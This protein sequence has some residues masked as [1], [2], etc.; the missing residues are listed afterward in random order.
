VNY[1]TAD[2]TATAPSDYTAGSGTVSF[3][4]G[5]SVQTATVSVAGDTLAEPNESFT[6]SLSAP[7]G[8]TLARTVATAT[9]LDDESSDLYTLTPCRLADTRDAPGASGGP[10]LA[11]NS[12]R[13]FPAAGACGVPADAKAVLLN[14]TVVGQTD[15]GN[16]RL[17]PAGAPVPL[18][19]TI[20]FVAGQTRANN[21]IIPLGVSGQVGVRCG[22]PTGSTHFV[23]DVFGYMK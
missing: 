9:I 2:G 3:S 19:S 5:S 18:A 10:A 4:A 12:T 8:A 7:A 17:Y 21:A 14:V 16:L 1:I 15:V 6:A 20:N 23:M 11:A 13:A 22:M